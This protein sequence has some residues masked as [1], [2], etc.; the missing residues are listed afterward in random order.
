MILAKGTADIVP[1][2][3]ASA[4]VR[5]NYMIDHVSGPEQRRLCEMGFVEG[6]NVS[7]VNRTREGMLVVKVGGSR[8]ALARGMADYVFVK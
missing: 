4:P 1:V 5:P 2:S 7:V 8:L 3:L 6:A